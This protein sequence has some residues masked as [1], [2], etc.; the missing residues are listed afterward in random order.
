[1]TNKLICEGQASLPRGGIVRG[2]ITTS[3]NVEFLFRNTY[4]DLDFYVLL[5][6][7]KDEWFKSGGQQILTPQSIID[8]LGRCIDDTILL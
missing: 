3:D 4:S 2:P 8:E 5:K 1:M 6:K 7:D